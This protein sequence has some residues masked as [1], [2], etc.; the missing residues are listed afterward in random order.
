ME[1]IKESIASTTPF[2]FLHVREIGHLDRFRQNFVNY[3]ENDRLLH[4]PILIES[5]VYLVLYMLE[6]S[7]FTLVISNILNFMEL[8]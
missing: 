4:F 5:K 1:G 8:S 3:V 7:L 2:N 6:L